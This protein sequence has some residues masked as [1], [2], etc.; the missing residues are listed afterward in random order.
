M[1]PDVSV[2][3]LESSSFPGAPISV[4]IADVHQLMRAV[5]RAVLDDAA[6]IEVRAEAAEIAL[7][8]QHVTGHRPDVLVL[9][10]H[11]PDGS[12][13]ELIGEL[14]ES[15]PLTHVVVVSVD[16][17]TAFARRALAAGASGYVLKDLASDD[18]PS[19][20]RAAAHGAPYIS[21]PVAARMARE[22]RHR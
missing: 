12:S 10:L 20:V 22:T 16:D 5:L 17:S 6:G 4:V 9:A 13:N 21:T 8:R 19:A 15:D 7:T 11:M 3:G 2:P 14:R 1:A 18:L